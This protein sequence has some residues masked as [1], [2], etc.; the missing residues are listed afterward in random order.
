MCLKMKKKIKAAAA[1]VIMLSAGFLAASYFYMNKKLH[2]P[3]AN[4]PAAFLAGPAAPGTRTVVC[5]G[6]SVTRGSVSANFVDMLS[7]RM[8]GKG[9]VF[10]NAGV[11]TELAYNASLRTG[12]VAGCRPDFVV[13]LIGT[14][15]LN[16]TLSPSGMK[17]YIR[18]MALP[19][20]P[21]IGWYRENMEKICSGLRDKTSAMIA[22]MSIP[23]IGEDP[24]SAGFTGSARYAAVAKE[25]ALKFGAAYLPL[26]EM[27]RDAII[28]SG[29][30][31]RGR[32][33]RDYP[34]AMYMGLIRRHI[35]RMD[36]AEISDKYGFM[37]LTDFIHLNERGAGMAAD[38]V[39]GFLLGGCTVKKTREGR[40][41]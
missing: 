7:S 2:E 29:A 39:E 35:L 26:N 10:V 41:T 3:P 17:H 13:V 28:A 27:M 23:V 33:E 19:K 36:F 12:E 18:S 37:L 20:R 14:N 22:V 11:N 5:L 38:L 31:A 16:A 9:Y 24:G 15:D 6:D 34:A 25:T 40:K 21:D 32:Y 1:A 4:S 8:N 30:R